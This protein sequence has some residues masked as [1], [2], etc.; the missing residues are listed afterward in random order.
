MVVLSEDDKNAR[1]DKLTVLYAYSI[2][3]GPESLGLAAAA[4]KFTGSGGAIVALCPEGEQ[5][6]EAL[7]AAC[8]KEGFTVVLVKVA[9]SR[10]QSG[11]AGSHGAKTYLDDDLDNIQ[12]SK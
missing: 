8:A 5:Q 6:E 9:P 4:A 2:I 11:P 1:G 10:V 3:K 12:T 7:K